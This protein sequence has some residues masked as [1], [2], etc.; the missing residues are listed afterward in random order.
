VITRLG[1]DSRVAEWGKWRPSARSRRAG[2][3]V[4][5]V[6]RLTMRDGLTFDEACAVLRTNHQL[7]LDDQALEQHYAGFNARSRPHFVSQ[8][9]IVDEP[10]SGASADRALLDRDADQTL[11]QATAALATTFQSLPA[12]D[13]A[14]LTLRFRDGLTVAAIAR[15]LGLDQKRLHRRF[16]GALVR[17]RRSLEQAHLHKDDILGA[18]GRA[19]ATPAGLFSSFAVDQAGTGE[20]EVQRSQTARRVARGSSAGASATLGLAT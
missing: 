4:V 18:I 1:L 12:Q 13:R 14:V 19:G 15:T 9:C 17:L 2:A 16:A 3:I 20:P 6:E 11:S 10:V 5:L 8:E 7:I